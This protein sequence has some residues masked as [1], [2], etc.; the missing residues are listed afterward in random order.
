MNDLSKRF[1]E[2]VKRQEELEEQMPSRI[3]TEVSK[4]VTTQ[5][6]PLTQEI[7]DHKEATN[8]TVENIL[9]A[10][11]NLQNSQNTQL[12]GLIKSLTQE[13]PSGANEAS[14]RGGDK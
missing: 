10:I 1:D 3:A 12:D 9:Q 13:T 11:Q 7:R 8:K 14:S 5:L 4:T 6:G 2:L